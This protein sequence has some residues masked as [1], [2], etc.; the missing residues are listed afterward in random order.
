M[1]TNDILF[2][3]LF[4]ILLFHARPQMLKKH[5]AWNKWPELEQ[6]QHNGKE[7]HLLDDFSL[8]SIHPEDQTNPSKIIG[9]Y[10][11]SVRLAAKPKTTLGLENQGGWIQEILGNRAHTELTGGSTVG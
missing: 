1:V 6:T 8:K 10:N 9:E 11:S 5:K 3:L 4:L 7:Q 2:V